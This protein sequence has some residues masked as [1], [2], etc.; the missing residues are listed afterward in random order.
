MPTT[1]AAQSRDLA[2][3][4]I[5]VIALLALAA[6]IW[7]TASVFLLAFG[8][9]L[10]AVFLRFLGDKLADFI[11]IPR[12]WAFA[13]VVIGI[14]LLLALACWTAV[15]HISAQVNQLIKMLPLGI[16]RLEA[17]LRGKA[18][19]RILLNFLPQML[20]SAGIAQRI[21]AL[22]HSIGD[23]IAGLVL[24]AALGIY[25]GAV[26]SVYRN[27]LLKLFPEH[28]RPRACEVLGEI[29]YTLRWWVLGQLIPMGALGIATGLGL[30]FLHVPLAFTLALF[31][32]F[33]IFIPYIGSLIA[34]IVTVLV[35]LIHGTSDVLYVAI[36]YLGIH[37]AEGYFLTPMVQR[38]AIYLPPA[39]AIL[40]QV[41]MGWLLGFIGFALA[42]PLTA[43]TL[44]AVKMLYLHERPE[45]HG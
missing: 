4:A 22:L 31:T 28:T 35:T 27:G 8:G 38:R 6:A 2:R 33:M 11:R 26:P 19:G 41:T 3:R 36:L 14:A 13:I 23:G 18:W 45:H 32:A 15:P 10:L 37:S 20:A 30:H 21:T 25:L 44:V 1:L 9:I 16:E 24:I 42:T 34:F 5:V 29:A 40:A 39:L 43:A 12:G 7:Y 17:Y